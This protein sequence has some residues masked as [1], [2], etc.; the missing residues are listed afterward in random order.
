[1]SI[2]MEIHDDDSQVEDMDTSDVPWCWFYLAECGAW[3]MFDYYLVTSNNIEEHYMNTDGGTMMFST[4]KYIYSLNFS[5]VTIKICIQQFFFTFFIQY[6]YICD[7]LEIS[8]PSHWENVKDESYQVIPLGTCTNEFKEVSK[9][10]TKTLNVNI[11]EIKRIQNIHL[12]E[13]FCR[14]KIQLSKIKQGKHI[15]EMKLFHGTNNENVHAICLDNFDP[16]LHGIHKGSVHGKGT[17]FARDASRAKKYCQISGLHVVSSPA[18]SSQN[19]IIFL[20]RV[21]VGE[22]IKGNSQYVRP[23]SKN[24]SSTN[25][26]DSCVDNESNPEIYVIFDRNQIYPEYIIEF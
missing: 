7:H 17:Y 19:R 4:N 20:A 23:P 13:F 15:Q 9:L 3:H 14:K 26:Y 16:R 1:M 11:K 24:S 18:G 22:F 5:A 10:F 21:L 25:F 6:R 12:W 8:V 2:R